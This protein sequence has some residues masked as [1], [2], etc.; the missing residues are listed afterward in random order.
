MG[1]AIMAGACSGPD[2]SVLEDADT[3][4]PSASTEPASRDS[5]LTRGMDQVTTGT[6]GKV[7]PDTRMFTIRADGRDM[8]FR[9]NDDT[10][11]TG[12]SGTQ[13][14]AG[15]EGDRVT[16][17]Y[18]EEMGAMIA[19]RIVLDTAAPADAAPTR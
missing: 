2:T 3:Q 15:R 4:N 14:L 6:I 8:S 19:S 9:Y 16:V 13:G 1:A 7:D 12:A 10:Q 18:R 5:E 17:H 11:V